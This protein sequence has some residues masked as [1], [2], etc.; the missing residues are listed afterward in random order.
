MIAI[1]ILVMIL[2]SLRSA[3][4]VQEHLPGQT[5]SIAT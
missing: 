2:A 4:R 5:T 1:L 3:K